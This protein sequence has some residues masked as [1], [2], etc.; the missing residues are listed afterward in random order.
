MEE[1]WK[2]VVGYEG[3]YEV[4]SEGR[5]KSLITNKLM[6][7]FGCGNGYYRVS[8]KGRGVYVHRIVAEAFIENPLNKKE[9][10]HLDEDPSNNCVENLEWATR[11]ENNNYGTHNKRVSASKSIPIEG[12]CISTGNKVYYSS[13]K[14]ASLDGFSS[15]HIGSCCKGKRK[16]TGG[17]TWKYVK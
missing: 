6:S 2:A 10:N 1:V 11:T 13:A 5:V 15:T 16:Q 3:L 8:L 4:S 7:I 14:E 12:T 9:V 17:F